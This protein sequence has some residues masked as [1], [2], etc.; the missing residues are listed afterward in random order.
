MCDMCNHP[1]VESMTRNA[2]SD[3]NAE[4]ISVQAHHLV[5]AVCVRGGCD[6]P[7][8]GKAVIDA[9][10]E[11]LWDFP[12]V[13]LKIEADVNAAR[14]NY[15]T[16]YMSDT[17]HPLPNGAEQRLAAWQVRR[18]DLEVCRLLGVYPGS[19][20][21]AYWVY[22]MLFKRLPDVARLCG[23][24][25]D[26][27]KT[28]CADMVTSESGAAMGKGAGSSAVWPACPHACADFFKKIASRSDCDLCEQHLK[29]EA[30]AEESRVWSMLRPRT[31]KEMHDAKASTSTYI[32]KGADT[33]VIRPT[34]L[35][36]L[37]CQR[38]RTDVIIED[39]LIELRDRMEAD[40][41]VPVRITEGCC[42]VCDPCQ[43]FH[44]GENVC[45]H[46]HPKNILRDLLILEKLDLA[47][48]AVLPARELYQ[49]IYDRIDSTMEVCA[50][51]DELNSTP[52]WAPCGGCRDRAIERARDE[53]WLQPPV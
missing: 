9:L 40:P 8:C 14:A 30:L 26:V 22:D 45:Y 27:D 44:P 7:P 17:E 24:A 2:A 20:M 52:F 5:C 37:L 29:G 53:R 34:H 15:R 31:R 33:L 48:G 50:W 28:R 49:R 13:M 12:H 47:P 41:E 18:K 19:I 11:K 16:L 46:G 1:P 35:L 36:C 51:G 3:E 6:S 23:G 4:P 42:M 25:V 21:P 10:L 43:V 38:H 39:N 32:R